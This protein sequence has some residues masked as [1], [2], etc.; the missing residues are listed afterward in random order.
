MKKSEK[1][2]MSISA[3]R[4]AVNFKSQMGNF[5]KL[6]SVSFC[7]LFC[8][9]YWHP[10]FKPVKPRFLPAHKAGFTGLKTGG[11]PG[12]WVV[13]SFP[14]CNPYLL[15]SYSLWNSNV[16]ARAAANEYLSTR[17]LVRVP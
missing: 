8:A 3:V 10:K 7:A 11:Y 15:R 17:V 4:A 1:S 9:V 6:L 2:D 12:F 16:K 13:P 14:S 5:N